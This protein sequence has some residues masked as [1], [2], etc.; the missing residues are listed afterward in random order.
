MNKEYDELKEIGGTVIKISAE[1]WFRRTYSARNCFRE[2]RS[3]KK[4]EA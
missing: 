1:E 4:T 3:G 2:G